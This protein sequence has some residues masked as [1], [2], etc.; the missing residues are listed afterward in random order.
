MPKFR[1]ALPTLITTPLVT[2][3]A[4]WSLAR[5]PGAKSALLSLFGQMQRRSL[6]VAAAKQQAKKNHRA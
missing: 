3:V 2:A 1:L 5:G 6:P 4:V